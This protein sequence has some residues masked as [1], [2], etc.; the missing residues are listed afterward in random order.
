MIHQ[1]S[2]VE[3]IEEA[4]EGESKRC[5]YCGVVKPLDQFRPSRGI[6]TR[7]TVECLS[8]RKRDLLKAGKKKKKTT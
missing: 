2:L 5:G 3:M 6:Q 7:V 4:V 8:C 1:D